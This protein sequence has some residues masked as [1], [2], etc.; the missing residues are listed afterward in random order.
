MT[1]EFDRGIHRLRTCRPKN[2]TTCYH[3]PRAI[4]LLRKEQQAW[5]AWRNA[6][7]D[8]L[9]FGVEHT[10]AELQVHLDCRTG[11]TL[12]RAKDLAK[13]GRD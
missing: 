5:L 4:M 7:C 3:M 6:S 2:S 1:A 13:V 9:A 12:E 10:S 11:K 8:L